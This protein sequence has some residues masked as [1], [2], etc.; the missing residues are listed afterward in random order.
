MFAIVHT[1]PC[2]DDRLQALDCTWSRL[3][4]SPW[5]WLGAEAKCAMILTVGTRVSVTLNVPAICILHCHFTCYHLV[6]Y[7]R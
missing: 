4:V 5:L 1:M 7:V 2:S 3:F 6:V